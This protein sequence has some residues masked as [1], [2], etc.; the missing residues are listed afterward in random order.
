MGQPQRVDVGG[1]KRA[2]VIGVPREAEQPPQLLGDLDGYAGA[3][4]DLEPGE[5]RLVTEEVGLD[6]LECPG[7][8]CVLRQ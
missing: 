3:L 1:R 7:E 4:G 2:L 8:P 5:R 6:V